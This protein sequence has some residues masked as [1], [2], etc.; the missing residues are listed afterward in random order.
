MAQV[1]PRYANTV[2]RA[3]LAGVVLGVVGII[4]G[5]MAYVRSPYETRVGIPIQQPVHFSHKHHVADDGIDCR[6]CHTSVETSSFAGIPPTETCMNCHS[7]I[8]ASSP[9]LEP[10]RQSFQTGKPIEWERVH[11]LPD[12]VYFNHSIHVN[13][14]IG[15]VECHG[16]V[17]LMETVYKQESLQMG[18][19]LDC[20]RDPAPRLRPPTEITNMS[21]QPPAGRD[22]RGFGHEMMQQLNVQSK[23]DCSV[24]HR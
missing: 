2:A 8:W 16:R 23:M 1:F 10:I 21:W 24:C 11:N 13:K 5:M 3:G 18:W 17:D 19:C 9:A 14:G 22:R 12:F 7:Q 4:G 6:Y 15:C 20:H